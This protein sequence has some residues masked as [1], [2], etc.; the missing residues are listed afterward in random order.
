M[1]L[2]VCKLCTGDHPGEAERAWTAV[3]MTLLRT[4][5]GGWGSRASYDE[6]GSSGTKPGDGTGVG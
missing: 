4:T 1:C 3:A 6:L 5:C 2:L